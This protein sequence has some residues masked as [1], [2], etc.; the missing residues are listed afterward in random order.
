MELESSYR[1]RLVT[2]LK[3][4]L[5]SNATNAEIPNAL[6]SVRNSNDAPSSAREFY[7]RSCPT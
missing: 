5:P 3:E 2:S 7:T 4:R 6:Q 1:L